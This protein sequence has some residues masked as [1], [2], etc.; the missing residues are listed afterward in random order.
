MI[1]KTSLY[2]EDEL[3]KKLKVKALDEDKKVN[4]III[5]LIKEKLK[6]SN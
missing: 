4:D 1:K 3:L 5:E 2:I 6:E